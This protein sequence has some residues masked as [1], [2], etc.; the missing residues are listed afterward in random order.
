LSISKPRNVSNVVRCT[1][2]FSATF[3]QWL[4]QIKYVIDT[5]VHILD[6]FIFA[7][8]VITNDF[9]IPMNTFLKISEELGVSVA[10]N[11]TV[12]PTTVLTFLNLNLSYQ[13]PSIIRFLN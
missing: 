6:Y 12:H 5:L 13:P 10:E 9:E 3:L 8:E 1:V 2:L 7:G 4:V 11:K